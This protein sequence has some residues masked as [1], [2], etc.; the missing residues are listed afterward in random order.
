MSTKVKSFIG[1]ALSQALAQTKAVYS[2]SLGAESSR[3]VATAS[4]YQWAVDHFAEVNV[5][6][7]DGQLLETTLIVT[8][9]NQRLAPEIARSIASETSRSLGEVS[10]VRQ[11]TAASAIHGSEEFLMSM[12]CI[13]TAFE[14]NPSF[15]A[16]L[17]RDAN[18]YIDRLA[19]T[20]RLGVSYDVG[21][22]LATNYLKF[23]IAGYLLMARDGYLVDVYATGSGELPTLK[24]FIDGTLHGIPELARRSCIIVKTE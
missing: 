15:R 19:K 21:I 18:A 10:P 1:V 6:L 5:F 12:D 14:N 2:V 11:V 17:K 3:I 20:S 7:G 13:N 8:G 24:E 9:V 4:G 23:E 22:E 16:S